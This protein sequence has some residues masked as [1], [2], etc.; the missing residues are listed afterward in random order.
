[1]SPYP[2]EWAIW[3]YLYIEFVHTIFCLFT[4]KV[5][6]NFCE[7]QSLKLEV[8]QLLKG[9]SINDVTPEGQGVKKAIRNEF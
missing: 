1:M 6:K 2:N 5:F 7:I 8:F 9:S 4:Y 3:K